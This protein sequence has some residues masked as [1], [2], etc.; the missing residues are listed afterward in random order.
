MVQVTKKE[1]TMLPHDYGNDA[2]NKEITTEGRDEYCFKILFH[3]DYL[4]GIMYTFDF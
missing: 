2:N 3:A 4:L 1:W